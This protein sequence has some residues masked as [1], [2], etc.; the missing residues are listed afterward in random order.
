MPP[1]C[2]VRRG[3]GAQLGSH[4]AARRVG[5]QIY[6]RRWQRPRT[7][8][9]SLHGAVRSVSKNVLDALCKGGTEIGVVGFCEMNTVDTVGC[10]D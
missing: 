6:L 10:D 7:A 3:L 5:S 1:S 4:S 2:A 8:A 9:C